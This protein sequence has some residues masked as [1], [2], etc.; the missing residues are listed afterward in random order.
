MDT[1]RAGIPPV[2]VPPTEQLLKR[3]QNL[4]IVVAPRMMAFITD[5]SAVEVSVGVGFDFKWIDKENRQIGG[6]RR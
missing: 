1:V 3:R 2:R 6:H 4:Q 5:W